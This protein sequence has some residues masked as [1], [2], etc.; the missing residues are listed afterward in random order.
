VSW[1]RSTS[2]AAG[3][4]AGSPELER[5]FVER[6]LPRL[7]VFFRARVADPDL[8]Q[9]LTQETI[10]AALLSLRAGKLREPAALDA[11]ILGVAR[12][13]LAEALRRQAKAPMA[14]SDDEIERAPATPALAPE[15]R[16]TVRNELADLAEADQRLLWLILIEGHR[17]AEVAPQLGLTEEA[18]RQRKSRLLRRLH[19]K[20]FA[21]PV[22]NVP[23]DTTPKL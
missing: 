6:Y 7:E 16:L 11:Y 14:T 2:V 3:I 12:N 17:P 18:V 15:L 20:L 10:V 9:E 21:S 5:E 13:Q 8:R 22:T 19:E 23:Q 1:I 4:Q